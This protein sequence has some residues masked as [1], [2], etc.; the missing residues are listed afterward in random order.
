MTLIPDGFEAIPMY[1]NFCISL[2]YPLN[3]FIYCR[4]SKQFRDTFKRLFHGGD[5]PLQPTP[6]HYQT[7]ASE[8]LVGNQRV[9]NNG[10]TAL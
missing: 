8:L 10:N 7:V 6:S 5:E 4:M 2:S 3:F 1:I 9:E